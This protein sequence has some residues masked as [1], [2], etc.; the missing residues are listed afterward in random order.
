[1]IEKQSEV[2]IAPIRKTVTVR[3]SLGDAFRIFTE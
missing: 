2:R 1:M 3:R